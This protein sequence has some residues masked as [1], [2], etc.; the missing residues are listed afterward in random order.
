MIIRWM[1]SDLSR[2]EY[3]VSSSITGFKFSGL[4]ILAAFQIKYNLF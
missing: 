1:L 3:I 2:L 4:D